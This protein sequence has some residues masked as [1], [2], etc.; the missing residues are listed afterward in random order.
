MFIII[1][2][3]DEWQEKKLQLLHMLEE[4][5]AVLVRKGIFEPDKDRDTTF[6]DQRETDTVNTGSST[7]R[8][9]AEE[10]T[11]VPDENEEEGK[12]GFIIKLVLKFVYSLDL[13]IFKGKMRFLLLKDEK[14]NVSAANIKDYFY[15]RI[16]N[17]EFLENYECFTVSVEDLAVDV[18]PSTNNEMIVNIHSDHVMLSNTSFPNCLSIFEE[19][20]FNLRIPLEKSLTKYLCNWCIGL[21]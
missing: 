8:E 17:T 5:K 13:K 10:N 11:F 14:F 15:D 21:E 6:D 19:V 3:F 2:E 12:K 20:C 4:I 9:R 18:S 1:N 16:D 7:P